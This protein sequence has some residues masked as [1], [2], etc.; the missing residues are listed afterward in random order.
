MPRTSL[1]QVPPPAKAALASGSF[2][3][4]DTDITDTE[5][6]YGDR[7]DGSGKNGSFRGFRFHDSVNLTV[8]D[9]DKTD[10]EL[11]DDGFTQERAE[12][13]KKIRKR[14]MEVEGREDERRKVSF[15]SLVGCNFLTVISVGEL[16]FKTTYT[17]S[18]TPMPEPHVNVLAN[19]S[20][21]MRWI[22]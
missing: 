7:G 5:M 12:Y 8:D 9:P 3:S 18:F 2:R 22:K 4:A 16:F 14:H 11:D 13:L 15:L 19:S 21:M 20:T 1:R 17:I 10:S 6:S